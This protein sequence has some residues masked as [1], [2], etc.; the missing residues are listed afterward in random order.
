MGAMEQHRHAPAAADLL[1]GRGRRIMVLSLVALVVSG[2]M[3]LLPPATA[4]GQAVWSGTQV[5]GLAGTPHLWVRDSGGAFHWVG[6][7]RALGATTVNWSA[8]A[9]VSLTQLRT[10]RLAG[11]Y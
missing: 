2:L 5:V 7:T 11:P 9:D 1:P 4:H 8:R 6:D 3:A 10:L